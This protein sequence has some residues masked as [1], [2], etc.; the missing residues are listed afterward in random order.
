MQDHLAPARRVVHPLEALYV[1]LD[2]VGVLQMG[3]VLTLTGHKRVDHSNFMTFLEQALDQVGAD[4]TTA[5]GDKYAHRA[6]PSPEAPRD[7][8]IA[9]VSWRP[10][11]SNRRVAS[12]SPAAP[13]SSD[14]T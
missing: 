13:G 8:Y 9:P 10:T 5:P 3:E 11:A 14:P 6:K 7:R 4:E 1:A 2:Q 12:S